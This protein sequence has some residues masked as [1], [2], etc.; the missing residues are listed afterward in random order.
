VRLLVQVLVTVAVLAYLLS[1]VPLEEI[2]AVLATAHPG[3]VV[4]GLLLQTA[5]RVP[6][7]IRMKVFTDAQRLGLGIATIISIMFSTSFY[8]L[9]LPGALAGGVAGWMKYVQHG[10][11]A[12]PALASMFVN[13]GAEV[14]ATL[15]VGAYWWALDGRLT[16][17][18]AVLFVGFAIGTLFA[19]YRLFLG[20]SHALAAALEHLTTGRRLRETFVYRKLHAFAAHLARVRELSG[21]ATVVVLLASLAQDLVAAATFYLLARALGLELSFVTVAWIRVAVHLLVM[22]PVSISG[23]GVREGT[24]VLLTAPYGIAAPEAVAWSFVIFAGTLLAA[25]TGGLIEARTLWKKR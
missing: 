7:A 8:G 19:A 16:G 21:K 17:V 13:R 22:L 25:S 23:L 9:L 2:L 5:A 24:L 12:G 14:L 10:A 18:T 3:Y 15:T 4:M 1:I 6:A 20:H 11:A